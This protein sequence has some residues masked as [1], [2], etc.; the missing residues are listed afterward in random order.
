MLALHRGIRIV[1]SVSGGVLLAYSLW[2]LGQALLGMATGVDAVVF[3]RAQAPVTPPDGFGVT[4]AVSFALSGLADLHASLGDH[5]TALACCEQALAPHRDIGD[6][7]RAA[8]L[9]SRGRALVHLGQFE[10]AIE[11]YHE[12]RDLF[13]GLQSPLHEGIVLGHLGD[14]HDHLGDTDRARACWQAGLDVLAG[15][16]GAA[17]AAEEI[18]AKL[19]GTVAAP[20]PL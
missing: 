2:L 17:A 14:A 12:A 10:K 15:L 18:R 13:R 6:L 11:S 8:V 16:S 9:D 1:P 20:H 19:D 5:A 4:I 3:G 7:A